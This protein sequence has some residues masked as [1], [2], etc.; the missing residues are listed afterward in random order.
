[1]PGSGVVCV[2]TGAMAESYVT[3][4]CGMISPFPLVAVV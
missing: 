3:I 1:L 4:D 2:R